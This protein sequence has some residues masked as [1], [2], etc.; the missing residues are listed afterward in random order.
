[1]E[2]EIESMI[3]TKSILFIGLDKKWKAREMADLFTTI[4]KL[5][6]FY[7]LLS[8]INAVDFINKGKLDEKTSVAIKVLFDRFFF[9]SIIGFSEKDKLFYYSRPKQEIKKLNFPDPLFI[10]RI[11]FSSPG[12]LE[13]LG[14]TDILTIIKEAIFKAIDV[15]QNKRLNDQKVRKEELQN[16]LL[17]LDIMERSVK[18]LKSVGVEKQKIKELVM[19]QVEGLGKVNKLVEEK[20]IKAIR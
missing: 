19:N 11:E 14:V 12:L 20:K 2:K 1:M 18:L 17:E 5:Y 15:C 4:Q 16:R 3:N 10:E 13:F 7:S 9:E 6:D 8:V